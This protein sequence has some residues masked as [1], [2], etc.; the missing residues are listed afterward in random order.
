MNGFIKK[1]S[2]I[3]L[4]AGCFLTSCT[5]EVVQELVVSSGSSEEITVNNVKIKVHPTFLKCGEEVI[6]E[7]EHLKDQAIPVVLSS[8]SLGIEDSLQTP[9]I[10]KKKISVEGEHELCFEYGTDPIKVATSITINAY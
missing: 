2:F 10:I 7:A 3:G 9:F 6:I 1:I 5:E 4:F 8:E